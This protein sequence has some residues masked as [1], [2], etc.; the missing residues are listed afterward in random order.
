MFASEPSPNPTKKRNPY[1]PPR[2][3]TL[4]PE[5]AQAA[6]ESLGRGQD[7]E[8]VAA[9]RKLARCGPQSG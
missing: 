8:P 4:T 6:L 1:N 5:A 3:T 7:D 9:G 2:L